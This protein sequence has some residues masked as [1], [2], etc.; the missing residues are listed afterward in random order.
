MLLFSI[1]F[2]FLNNPQRFNIN[3]DSYNVL[4][5]VY[6]ITPNDVLAV[7]R[8]TFC[9]ISKTIIIIINGDR[10]KIVRFHVYT[11]DVIVVAT[12]FDL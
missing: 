12:M 10:K 5:T 11:A 3:W 9:T 8:R 2:R 7:F 1:P 4:C 6:I